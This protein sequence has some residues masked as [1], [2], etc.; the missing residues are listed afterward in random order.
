MD[1]E[2]TAWNSKV[3]IT[4]SLHDKRV[5]AVFP[6]FEDESLYFAEHLKVNKGDAVLDIGT[7][8]GILGIAAA[9]KA[10]H[11]TLL[12]IEKR[13]LAF[14]AFNAHLNS[15]ENK[16]DCM[17]SDGLRRV[18]GRFDAVLFNPPF[19]PAPRELRGKVFSRGGNDGTFVTRK[20]FSELPGVVKPGGR[21]QMITF[22]LGKNG[23]PLVFDLIE[24]F[25]SSRNPAVYY[26]HLYAPAVHKD[27]RY[28]E[29]VFGKTYK[30]WYC[31]FDA[32][33]EIY[34][35]FLTTEFDSSKPAFYDVPLK[36][37]FRKEKYSGSW[38]ARIRR[39][40]CVYRGIC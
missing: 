5:D 27:L 37:K 29:R 10:K 16:T 40:R 14:A 20:V 23:Q 21:L 24:T 9:A 12:D 39:L 2:I 11:A 28:F 38:D 3:F 4:D 1:M 36:M 30:K 18:R 6:L 7:G 34:Y 35:L 19:N 33:P 17:Q 32:L 8:S 25:L 31:Q 15:V 26:T 22:S 13:A